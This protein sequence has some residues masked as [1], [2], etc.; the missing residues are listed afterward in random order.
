MDKKELRREMKRRNTAMTPGQRVVASR[1]IMRRIEA[2]EA[3][4]AAHCVALFCALRDE[5]ATGEMLAR[6]HCGKRLALP[7]VEGFEM[8]F[9]EYDPETLVPGAFGIIEPGPA[10]RPCDPAE[11][12]LMVV[13][14]VAFTLSGARL[15]RGRGYYDK[16]L[17]Q[18]AVRAV[19]IGVCYE[20]Q[21]VRELPTEAHD[22]VM[23]CVYS[24]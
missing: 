18:P 17:S 20:H 11:I 5:P 16:Y 9:F 4:A 13:P 14:G 1:R 12:D 24:G 2:S 22:I 21:L 19:K 15:G 23:D 6:W 7:R 8:R 3:F 10:A